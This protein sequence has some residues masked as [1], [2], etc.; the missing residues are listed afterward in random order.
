MPSPVFSNAASVYANVGLKISALF[1]WISNCIS[2]S[3]FTMHFGEWYLLSSGT[4]GH[5]KAPL[6]L[7]QGYQCSLE[8]HQLGMKKIE[9]QSG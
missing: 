9:L 3:F 7:T 8:Y 6:H 4:Y 2:D 5:L 1:Q